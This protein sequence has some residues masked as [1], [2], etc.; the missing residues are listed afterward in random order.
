MARYFEEFVANEVSLSPGRTITAADVEAFAELT[1]DR[2]ELHLSDAAAHASGFRQR[3]VHGAL[4][5]SISVGLLQ[6]EDARRP[7]IIAFLGVE[8]LR[9]VGPVY[10]G[11]TICV[12]QTVKSLDPVSAA[13]GLLEVLEEVLNQDDVVKVSFTAKFLI[14]RANATA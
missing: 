10:L 7:R 5:F 11:D 12:R 14:G 2:N 13:A 9:F 8:R 3:V 6:A 1:G 4:V